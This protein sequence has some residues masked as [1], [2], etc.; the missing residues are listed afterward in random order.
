MD[1]HHNQTACAVGFREVRRR[2]WE[3][4]KSNSKLRCLRGPSRKHVLH[5]E[6]PQKRWPY[7]SG[8]RNVSLRSQGP[9]VEGRIAAAAMSIAPENLVLRRVSGMCPVVS[10]ALMY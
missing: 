8:F 6:E 3:G 7:T 9:R 5:R 2:R 4:N 10:A 1:F